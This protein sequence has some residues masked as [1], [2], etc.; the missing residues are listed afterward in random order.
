MVMFDLTEK[1]NARGILTDTMKERKG[2]PATRQP[3]QNH[4]K[5]LYDDLRTLEKCNS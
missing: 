1:V 4:P 5:L 3:C 2:I